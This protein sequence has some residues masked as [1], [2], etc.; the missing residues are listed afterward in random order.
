MSWFLNGKKLEDGA[1]AHVKHDT[2]TGKTSVRIHKP[3]EADSGQVKAVAENALGKTEATADLKVS[4]KTEVPKFTTNMD[5]RQVNEGT[6]VKYTSTVEG[7]P[8]PTVE[9]T[10]NGEPVTK[11]P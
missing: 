2:E 9:W 3:K 1:D 8:V 11:H 4:R 7:Y 5:D 6:T 10:L